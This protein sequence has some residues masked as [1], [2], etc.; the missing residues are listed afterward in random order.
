MMDKPK[1]YIFLGAPTIP[2]KTASST[3]RDGPQ[4]ETLDLCLQGEKLLPKGSKLSSEDGVSDDQSTADNI[5]LTNKSLDRLSFDPDDTAQTSE[6]PVLGI[7]GEYEDV[8]QASPNL[9]KRATCY[10]QVHC[11]RTVK[12]YLDSCFP[13][14]GT[15]PVV[16]PAEKEAPPHLSLE[17]EYLS[18]WTASQSL[19]LKGRLRPQVDPLRD[20]HE[21]DSESTGA[22]PTPQKPAPPAS[23][24]SPELYSPT[25]SPGERGQ[26]GSQELF[27]MLS[28]R[29]EEGGIV[30][31]A[32]PEGVLCSQGSLM[33]NNRQATAER[34]SLWATPRPSSALCTSP[35][36]PSSKR[37]RVS[38]PRART[39]EGPGPTAGTSVPPQCGPTTLL[40]RCTSTGVRYSVLVA[41]VYPCHLKEI[42]VKS[43]MWAGSTVPLATIVVTDQ[44][45]VNMKVVLWRTAAFWALTVNPGDLLLIT[46]VTLN[47]DKWRG[48]LVL[49]STWASRLLNLGQLT[50]SHPPP[51]GAVELLLKTC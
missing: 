43:G 17:T 18:V 51:G 49:Q 13:E 38:P 11:P 4:W 40:S 16:E 36:C 1:V 21:T 25:S 44:S 20:D 6:T 5:V 28:E 27:D 3:K 47:E 45:S 33:A 19:L 9:K 8:T 42:K 23:G 37:S 41:V 48:E 22:P 46:G 30:L 14:Q 7:E 34:G 39:P 15:R 10:E 2:L 24:S 31:E 35:T 32:T 29:Q 50:S 26:E 12:E